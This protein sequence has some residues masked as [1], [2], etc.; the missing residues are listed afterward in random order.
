MAMIA[1]TTSSSIKVKARRRIAVSPFFH[2]RVSI[3]A[4]APLGFKSPRQYGPNLAWRPLSSEF[5]ARKQAK[6]PVQGP[7]A[8]RSLEANMKFNVVGPLP[9][10]ATISLSLGLFFAGPGV[11]PASAQSPTV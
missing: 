6:G 11:Q 1:I 10:L 9:P 3:I 4:P 5:P 8:A 2:R 7:A